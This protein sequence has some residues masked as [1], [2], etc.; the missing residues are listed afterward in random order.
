MRPYVACTDDERRKFW[1]EVHD[2]PDAKP[3]TEVAEALM[4]SLPA[5][6]SILRFALRVK[7]GGSL[8]RPRYIAIAKWRGGRIVREA[9][10]LVP[11]AWDWAHGELHS[12]S[13]FLDLATGIF[14][15][16]DPLLTIKGR[17]VIRR[18]AADSRKVELGSDQGKELRDD[19]LTAMGFDLGAIH[20]AQPDILG[21][22]TRDLA[23]RP[24]N[25]LDAA[26]KMAAGAVEED[27]AE[28]TN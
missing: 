1:K 24:A 11:S 20:A 25:W 22:I 26:A 3:P 10:A 15:S 12:R 19:L 5:G 17:F 7:G 16:P 13:R 28:W 2:Y 4:Q 8:G 27:F 6:A 18:I 23:A 9:K 14:R 21:L